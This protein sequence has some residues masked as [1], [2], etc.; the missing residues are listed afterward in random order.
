M[1]VP[2]HCGQD[3][4]YPLLNDFGPD[5]RV[6]VSPMTAMTVTSA[7]AISGSRRRR[8][9]LRRLDEPVTQQR[10]DP[11][12]VQQIEMMQSTEVAATVDV[13]SE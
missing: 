9:K 7:A 6:T 10:P 4:S 3:T 1:L 12:M 2:E 13:Q 5:E 8:A 11:G